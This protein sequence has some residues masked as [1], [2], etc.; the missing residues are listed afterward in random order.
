MISALEGQEQ[1][2][3]SYNLKFVLSFAKCAHICDTEM[4]KIRTIN[5]FTRQFSK[6]PGDISGFSLAPR[7]RRS[8]IWVYFCHPMLAVVF[9]TD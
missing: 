4:T 1:L 9:A 8:P 3:T 5:L 7:L 6:I 2:Q